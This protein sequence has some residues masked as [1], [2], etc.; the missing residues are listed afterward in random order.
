MHEDNGQVALCVRL[1]FW[2]LYR[3]GLAN[4]RILATTND[5]TATRRHV[6]DLM[7]LLVGGKLK[8][9]LRSAD[10]KRLPSYQV[11]SFPSFS[12]LRQAFG[13]GVAWP[14]SVCKAQRRGVV[15]WRHRWQTPRRARE[16][17]RALPSPS[18]PAHTSQLESLQGEKRNRI[19]FQ[20]GINFFMS[21]WKM[22]RGNIFEI[23]IIADV[24][25]V[26]LSVEIMTKNVKITTKAI[27]LSFGFRDISWGN[28]VQAWISASLR[29]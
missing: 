1:W 2:N 10:H 26:N 11:Q 4:V 29:P 5:C 23:K 14:A 7:S 15:H 20:V 9:S 12:I 27:K 25:R 6:H 16:I 17:R 19:S 13:C 28:R 3:R 8:V 18:R 21:G 22:T 24:G